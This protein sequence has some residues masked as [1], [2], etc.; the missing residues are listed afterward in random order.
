M[1]AICAGYYEYYCCLLCTVQMVREIKA[2]QCIEHENV[3]TLID[4]FPQGLS[5][6]LVFEFMPS[7]L[8]E[9][10]DNYRLNG[11]QIK[12]YMNMLLKALEYL[13][14]NH[15]LHRVGR[16]DRQYKLLYTPYPLI[17]VS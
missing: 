9:I 13:H 1:H 11:S 8:W 2:L 15:I 7:N 6:V 17:D 12:C 3:V 16:I 10:L 5:F 14:E 4:V